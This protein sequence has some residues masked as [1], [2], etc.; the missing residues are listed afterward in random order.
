MRRGTVGIPL[1]QRVRAGAPPPT[2]G[3]AAASRRHCWVEAGAS[4]GESRPGLIAAWER[5]DDGWYAYVLSVTSE[6][7]GIVQEW[8]PAARVRPAGVRP[9]H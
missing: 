5:R 8:L 4:G 2:P 6:P 3:G 9:P 1:A 7:Y